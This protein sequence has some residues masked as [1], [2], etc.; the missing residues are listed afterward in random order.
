MMT[1]R[2]RRRFSDFRFSEMRFEISRRSLK[3]FERG[4][5]YLPLLLAAFGFV[6]FLSA[7]SRQP[8]P[9]TQTLPEALLSELTRIDDR[10]HLEGEAGPFTGIMVEQYPEG[11]PKS[12]SELVEGVLHGVSEGWHP[13]GVLQV[14]EQFKA[15][16]SNGTRYRWFDDGVPHTRAE[17]VEGQL[18]GIFL[19]WYENGALA[20]RIEMRNGEPDGASLAY[21]SSGYLKA[22]AEMARGKVVRQAFWKDGETRDPPLQ[23]ARTG[24][25]KRG[26]DL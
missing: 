5:E 20:E 23:E 6:F 26:E 1:C 19:R 8:E 13:N 7:C 24:Q 22:S 14:R 25:A 2:M 10:L 18:H 16:V 4:P 12:R 9:P 11:A 21:Y 15:G 17:I 3:Q